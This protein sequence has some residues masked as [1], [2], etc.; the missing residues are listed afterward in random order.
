MFALA[1]AAA[2]AG[3]TRSGHSVRA[4]PAAAGG[5]SPHFERGFSLREPD[6]MGA[7]SR[8]GGRTWRP[9]ARAASATRP[10]APAAPELLGAGVQVAGRC[11]EPRRLDPAQCGSP[12][13]TD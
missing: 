2:Q 7:A 3:K 12:T 6:K 8:A 11:A 1:L 4:R 5:A 13:F 10:A 9:W